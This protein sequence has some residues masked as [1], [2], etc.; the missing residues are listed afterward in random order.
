MASIGQ[1]ERVTIDQCSFHLSDFCGLG[2]GQCRT[3]TLRNC[4]LSYNGNT[5]LGM[6]ACQDC[7]VENCTLLFNN[8]RRFYA[9]WH[10]GGMKCIPANL[11]CTI[12]NCEAAYNVASDG[13]WFDSENGDIRILGNVCHHN[14]GAGIFFEINKKGGIIANNLVY[15]NRGR[16]IYVSGSQ[17][18][19]IVHN[20]VA[21]NES[22]IVCMPRGDEWPLEN[23]HVLNNLLVRNYVTA[24]TLTRGCDLTLFMGCRDA[25]PYTRTV[26]SNHSDYNTFA[27]TSWVPTMRDSWN[28]DNTLAQ[29]RERFGEDV[30]SSL[31]P[32]DFRQKG[33]GFALTTLDGLSKA[34]PLPSDLSKLVQP[35]PHVGCRRTA[36]PAR[37]SDDGAIGQHSTHVNRYGATGGQVGDEQQRPRS[38]SSLKLSENQ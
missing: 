9:G 10:C 33:T 35:P 24:D 21:C 31:V 27:N 28:P 19:W 13:I 26:L 32:V 1:C 36:W 20:T 18:T 15:A 16:G 25:A 38:P 14:D 17:N 5:G 11:R 23:V 4:D 2:I 7:L 34:E 30:H 22:G 3:C 8:Y 29:W 6:G 12:R 37:A